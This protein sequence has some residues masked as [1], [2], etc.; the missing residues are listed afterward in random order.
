MQ[1]L[2]TTLRHSVM[3]SGLAAGLLCAPLVA[4]AG[5]SLGL[6]VGGVNVDRQGID[7]G[8]PAVGASVDRRGILA[9]APGSRVDVDRRGVGVRAPGTDLDISRDRRSAVAPRGDFRRTVQQPARAPRGNG[10]LGGLLGG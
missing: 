9:E 8:A 5:L 6:P 7:V 10:L 4:H 3:T 1:N 2:G